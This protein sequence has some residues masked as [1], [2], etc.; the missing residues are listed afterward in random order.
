MRESIVIIGGGHAAAQLC[1]HLPTAGLGAPVHLICEEPYPPYQRPPLSKSFLKLQHEEFQHHHPDAWYADRGVTMHLGEC[2]QA[3]DRGLREVV[4]ASGSK[5]RYGKLVLATG[6]RARTA[7]AIAGPLENVT[8]L[9]TAQDANLLR[10]RLL[11][12]DAGVLQILGGGFIGLEVA[13]SARQL[14]WDVEILEAG[15]RLLAR[16]ASPE[17]SAHVLRHHVRMGVRVEMAVDVGGFECAS[18]R[19]AS[20]HVNGLR[21]PVDELLVG[22]GA[23]P[24]IQLA[25]GCGIAVDDGILVDGR[26]RTSDPDVLAIGDC[27]S[28]PY[29]GRRLR[30]ESIQNANDQAKVAAATLQGLDADY[31]PAPTFWSDQGSMRLQM[32]GLWRPGLQAVSR[33]GVRS[34]SCSW[35]HFADAELVAIESVNAPVDHMWGRKLLSAGVSP[36]SSQVADPQALLKSLM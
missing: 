3:I 18:G 34:E 5:L 12:Q 21:K 27:A 9:R 15:P 13:A 33:P 8:T 25:Q 30:L 11:R 17:L 28:F 16:A 31:T 35:F 23:A 26:M 4:L 29:L 36:P 10:Q 2:V 1:A 7:P 14:G 22:I 24:N 6:T 19:L 20:M 32:A